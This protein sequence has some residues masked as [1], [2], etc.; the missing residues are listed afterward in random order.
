MSQVT[1]IVP[2]TGTRGAFNADVVEIERYRFV[3]LAVDSADPIWSIKLPA[4]GALC[5]GVTTENLLPNQYGNMQIGGAAR[6]TSGA[7]I[8]R[9]MT[10]TCDSVGRAVPAVGSN[11]A[12]G[13]CL[14]PA[15]G[16]DQLISVE[17]T[18]F[19]FGAGGSGEANTGSNIGTGE[20]VFSAK[21]GVDLRFKSLL[22]LDGM[23]ITDEGDEVG[24]SSAGSHVLIEHAI[25]GIQT[26]PAGFTRLLHHGKMAAGSKI[27]IED[28]AVLK[29]V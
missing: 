26:V 3:D 27:I 20:G 16:I 7:A 8:D 6:L 11:V 28:G 19:A 29:N 2:A 12:M 5:V 14:T 15:T 10:V 21:V 23:T 25:T 4:A 17:L 24:I 9:G 22:G 18:G 1:A 13:R